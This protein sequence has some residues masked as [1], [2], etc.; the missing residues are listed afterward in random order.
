MHKLITLCRCRTDSLA[1]CKEIERERDEAKGKIDVMSLKVNSLEIQLKEAESRRGA[2]ASS[3]ADARNIVE[4][5][6]AAAR[7]LAD[8]IKVTDGEKQALLESHAALGEERDALLARCGSLEHDM[9]LQ[10]KEVILLRSEVMGMGRLKDEV[11][12]LE[13]EAALARKERS[14]LR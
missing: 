7:K 12:K 3:L 10:E 6:D 11:M 13:K 1:S 2:I 8:A 5:K 14:A 4:A 9:I